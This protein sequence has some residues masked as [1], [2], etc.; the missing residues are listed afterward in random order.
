L[1]TLKVELMKIGAT[2]EEAIEATPS[3]SRRAGQRAD[4]SK[5]VRVEYPY[6]A[7]DSVP[8]IHAYPG[9]GHLKILDRGRI[10]RYN[11]VQ[12]GSRHV[13]ADSAL[14]AAAGNP[15]LVGAINSVLASV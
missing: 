13:Q 3:Q 15:V 4:A 10:R 6:G 14:A 2:I 8:H 1:K 7:A 12:N 9:G 5:K 11:I